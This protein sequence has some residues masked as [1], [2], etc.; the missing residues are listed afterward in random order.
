[1]NQNA[2]IIEAY[3]DAVFYETELEKAQRAR[4]SAQAN[5]SALMRG[6]A[7][8]AITKLR[9]QG[10][11]AF[12]DEQVAR[13]IA[14]FL[15]DT[16][17]D[18]AEYIIFMRLNDTLND[19][20]RVLERGDETADEYQYL[21]PMEVATEEDEDGTFEGLTLFRG[22]WS[23]SYRLASVRLGGRVTRDHRAPWNQYAATITEAPERA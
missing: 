1:M 11:E 22:R 9:E 15:S 4:D 19:I 2:A 3:K 17:A 16:P 8:A 20:F 21:A 12:E 18:D 13:V 5:Y 6:E 10:Q 14:F 23:V 7:R